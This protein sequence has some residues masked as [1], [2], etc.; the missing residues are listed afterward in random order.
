MPTAEKWILVGSKYPPRHLSRVKEIG[1]EHWSCEKM[2]KDRAVFFLISSFESSE[3]T[4]WRQ[5]DIQIIW[6]LRFADVSQFFASNNMQGRLRWSRRQERHFLFSLACGSFS[7]YKRRNRAKVFVLSGFGRRN[8][9]IDHQTWLDSI[10]AKY[11]SCLGENWAT[12]K[13]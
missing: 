4:V 8:R 6:I 3:C 5:V 2:T 7:H 11:Y 12:I 10:T 1:C 13:A 9:L